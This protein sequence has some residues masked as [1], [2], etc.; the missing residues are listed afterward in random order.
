MIQPTSGASFFLKKN[1]KKLESRKNCLSSLLIPTRAGRARRWR[2]ARFRLRA[3]VGAGHRCG[4]I[5]GT[6]DAMRSMLWPLLACCATALVGG[7]ESRHYQHAVEAAVLR[8]GSLVTLPLP[9]YVTDTY[10]G[11]WNEF[12]LS[13]HPQLDL[14]TKVY[15][16]PDPVIVGNYSTATFGDRGFVLRRLQLMQRSGLT[17]A[18]HIMPHRLIQRA[19]NGTFVLEEWTDEGARVGGKL[20]VSVHLFKVVYQPLLEKLRLP[21][22]LI[23]DMFAF[24]DFIPTGLDAPTFKQLYWE[25]LSYIHRTLSFENTEG[26]D[27]HI[28]LKEYTTDRSATSFRHAV[29]LFAGSPKAPEDRG[30]CDIESLRMQLLRSLGR[31]NGTGSNPVTGERLALDNMFWIH[32][33][34]YTPD[35]R[36]CPQLKAGRQGSF[37]FANTNQLSNFSVALKQDAWTES[38]DDLGPRYFFG[39]L[40]HFHS[41]PCGRWCPDNASTAGSG[42]RHW[43]V[44]GSE[45]ER[46]FLTH[47][48][49]EKGIVFAS[50]WNDY[51]EACVLEPSVN[52][53]PLPDRHNATNARFL[54]NVMKSKLTPAFQEAQDRLTASMDE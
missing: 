8:D 23:Y 51:E 27:H 30:L 32:W 7:R 40:H 12:D 37:N 19:S 38:V 22:M 36:S 21:Y 18:L 3:S 54:E 28:R 16:A 5:S 1:T 41:N 24:A 31:P 34:L 49:R 50:I 33:Y 10:M 46:L 20:I 29:Y 4:V 47:R 11:G 14:S 44:S 6:I 15:Y 26:T 35:V 2:A 9:L 52:T 48:A 25:E 17:P 13:I 39:Y 53:E 43:S 45:T 42:D